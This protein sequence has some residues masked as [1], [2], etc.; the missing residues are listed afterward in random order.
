MARSSEPRAD[1]PDAT[2]PAAANRPA[3]DGAPHHRRQVFRTTAA[4]RNTDARAPLFPVYSTTSGDHFN[5]SG[6]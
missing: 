2:V 3:V 1:V 4:V 5:V 6:G